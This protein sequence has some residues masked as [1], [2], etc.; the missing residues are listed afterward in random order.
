MDMIASARN[1]ITA[2]AQKFRRGSAS[3]GD[4][5]AAFKQEFGFYPADFEATGPE[6][7]AFARDSVRPVLA[8]R[9]SVIRQ[10]EAYS[11]A[12]TQPANTQASRHEK[13]AAFD[14][15]YSVARDLKLAPAG[16]TW[17]DFLAKDER[18]PQDDVAVKASR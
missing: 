7:E 8:Q 16:K 11:A 13:D 3:S 9:A 1:A 4:R 10:M 15:A 5:R 2:S 14:R 6:R 18:S 17:Q 12:G